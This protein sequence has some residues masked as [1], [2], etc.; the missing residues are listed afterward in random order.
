MLIKRTLQREME[1]GESEYLNLTLTLILIYLE[2]NPLLFRPI[3]VPMTCPLVSIDRIGCYRIPVGWVIRKR[4]R[5]REK[6][7]E[8]ERERDELM[9]GWMD[10]I[11]K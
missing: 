3:T 1:R 7:R 9:N 2:P 5:E 6:E 8:R 10:G 4:E 11:N